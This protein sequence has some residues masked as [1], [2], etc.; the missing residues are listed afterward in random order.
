MDGSVDCSTLL[1]NAQGAYFVK[2]KGT[3]GSTTGVGFALPDYTWVETNSSCISDGYIAEAI[4]ECFSGVCE[5][6]WGAGPTVAQGHFDTAEMYLD[7][8]RQL[9]GTSDQTLGNVSCLF[10]QLWQCP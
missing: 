8:A 6:Y 1:A 2:T 3:C 4:N 7:D 10:T 9:C 5:S